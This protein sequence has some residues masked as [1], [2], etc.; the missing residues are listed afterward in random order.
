MR[1]PRFEYVRPQALEEAL[2]VLAQSGSRA[3]ILAGGTDL[4]VNM[5]QRTVCPEVVVSI[6]TLPELL[7]VSSDAQGFTAIGSGANLTD[8][9]ANAGIAE[10][11]PAF[12][13]AVRAIASKHIRNMACIGGNVCLDTR[14]WYYNQSKL[15]RDSPGALPS[16]RRQ[17]VPRHQG[18][19]PLPRDQQL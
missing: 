6:K 19:S 5:K 14:C 11:F 10:K 4:L 17:R 7:M 13:Q 1:L 9:A 18:S 12:I 16:D 15:W 2:S 3:K 8:L